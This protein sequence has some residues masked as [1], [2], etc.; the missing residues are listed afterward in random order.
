MAVLDAKGGVMA[1]PLSIKRSNPI[2][3]DSTAIWSDYSEMA[4]Y[5]ANS[6]VAYVGQILTL[7]T[8][9]N[10]VAYIIKDTQGALEPLGG[11]AD[12]Q[13]D[14][15]SLSKIDEGII[16]LH[17]FGKQYYAYTDDG[18][19][20]KEVDEDNPWKAGLEPRVGADLKLAWFEPSSITVEGLS[21][22]VTTLQ[23]EVTDIDARVLQLQQ[24][25]L[26]SRKIVTEL[27]EEFEDN[28]IYMVKEENISGDA[29]KEYL[30]IDGQLQ[31]IGDTSVDLSDYAK[32]EDVVAGALIGGQVAE[33]ENNK[34]V[35][36]MASNTV[37]GVV[38]GSEDD[39][40]ISISEEGD[41]EV[42]SLNVEK[43]Y[44][45]DADEFAIGGGAANSFNDIE[46]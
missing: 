31:Q 42:N 26:L 8:E 18:Y 39:D 45:E 19:E 21:N 30:S 7:V 20:L 44:V 11:G 29:Y 6:P 15:A 5:A 2:P 43:L 28:I 23:T 10:S 35:I 32:K 38:K 25:G 14:E 34:I 17:N 9:D 40:K 37:L 46:P 22:I 12:V 36:P 13:V 1:L 3:L 41:M 24:A 33:M 16:A 4:D 27:P